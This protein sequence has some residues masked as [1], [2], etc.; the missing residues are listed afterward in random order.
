MTGF[1]NE[2]R[3]HFGVEPICRVMEFAPSTYWA[4]RSRPPSDRAM[5]DERLKPE[6]ERVHKDNYGVYG[7]HKVWKQMN[8]EGFGVARCTVARL[9]RELELRGVRRGKTCRTTVPDES[10]VR[11]ADLV[12]RLFAAERPYQLWVADFT[13]VMNWTGFCY[14]AF[15]IDVFSRMIFRLVAFD[16]AQDRHAPGGAGHGAVAAGPS[17]SRAG[18]SLRPRLP[19]HLD[20]LYGTP[21][22]GRH[23]PVDR[24]DR[25]CVRQRHGRVH[26]RPVQSRAHLPPV[27]V[28][29]A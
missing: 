4:A 5:R 3:G 17:A 19:V 7:V 6:V 15:V 10:A 26:H 9:M 21:R 24:L 20:P 2:H 12:C 27:A 14:A 13:Y 11:P 22:R 18:A 1:I 28:A 23:R 8:R 16:L 29:N 25:R